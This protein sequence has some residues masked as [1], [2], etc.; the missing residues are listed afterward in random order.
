M[1]IRAMCNVRGCGRGL[2]DFGA[3]VIGP[4]DLERPV[5]NHPKYHVCQDCAGVVRAFMESFGKDRTLPVGDCIQFISVP[6]VDYVNIVAIRGEYLPQIV[7]KFFCAT[8]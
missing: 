1:A 4:E 8:S 3:I 7:R 2:N 5:F 6:K